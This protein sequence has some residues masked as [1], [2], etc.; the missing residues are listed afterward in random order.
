MVCVCVG[1]GGGYICMSLLLVNFALQHVLNLRTQ[2]KWP[3]AIILSL[4]WPIQD[5]WPTLP[6]SAMFGPR[7]PPPSP[8]QGP[9][10]SHCAWWHFCLALLS[11]LVPSSSSLE[12][13]MDGAC[14]WSCCHHSDQS[15]LGHWDLLLA[16]RSSAC[17]TLLTEGATPSWFA[18][19]AF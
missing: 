17:F 2:S 11:L 7:P 1:R 4:F 12:R 18:L 10:T 15:N 9:S 3:P 6:W 19:T 13:L 14:L 5:Y 8:S 16:A